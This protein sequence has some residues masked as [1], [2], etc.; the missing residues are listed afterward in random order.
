MMAAKRGPGSSRAQWKR[1]KV[2]KVPLLHA[3]ADHGWS[4]RGIYLETLA[5]NWLAAQHETQMPGLR[6][7]PCVDRKNLEG[8]RASAHHRGPENNLEISR[9]A[10]AGRNELGKCRISD[11]FAR[12]LR[13]VRLQAAQCHDPLS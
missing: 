1:Q 11:Q 8:A 7:L 12:R 3:V 5:L 6:N 10:H 9:G 4:G 13:A 2:K